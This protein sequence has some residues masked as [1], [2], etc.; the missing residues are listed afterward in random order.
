MITKFFLP[1]S[2]AVFIF[3]CSN[4]EQSIE[5]TTESTQIEISDKTG[6]DLSLSPSEREI[7]TS[8]GKT[9]LVKESHPKGKSLSDISVLFKDDSTTTLSLTDKD[10]ISDVLVGDLDKNGYDEIYIITTAA[11]SGSYGTV[12]GFASN[13]D[14]SFSL[15]YFP[16]NDEKELKDG[17]LKGYTGHDLY[18][19]DGQT[20]VRTFPVSEDKKETKTLSYQLSKTETGYTL[21]AKK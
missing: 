21:S 12:H 8:S 14:K 13:K 9:V 5:I 1:L 3:S 18:K 10:P 6:V 4:E 2:L 11:G 17:V 15:I 16:E 20:L 7:K 19:I